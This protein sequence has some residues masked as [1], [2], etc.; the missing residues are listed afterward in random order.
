VIVDC[1]V[2][3]ADGGTRTAAITGGC[4]ALAQ[5]ME[6]LVAAGE[7]TSSPLHGLVAAVSVGMVRGEP[8]LDLDY[9][10]DVTADVDMNFAALE[11]GRIVE[12]QGTAEG[13][14]FSRRELEALLGLAET[15]VA[16]LIALQRQALG[17]SA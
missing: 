8:C 7:L 4:V 16:R 17:L 13:A 10:E 14:A 9:A 11:D 12:L 1:D 15:G 3:G 5:A 6:R 2:L